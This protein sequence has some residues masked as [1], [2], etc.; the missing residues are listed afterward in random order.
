MF[1]FPR[2]SNNNAANSGQMP[3][4]SPQQVSL[5]K[6]LLNQKGITAEAWVRQICAQ[7]GIDVEEYMSQFKDV[8][9]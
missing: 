5:V 8:S 4:V 2:A 7:R 6:N 9:L 1:S 3:Q